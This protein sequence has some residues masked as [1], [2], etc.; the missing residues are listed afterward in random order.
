MHACVTVLLKRLR[1]EDILRQ[2]WYLRT[3]DPYSV[4]SYTDVAGKSPFGVNWRE[5][6]P[7]RTQFIP[8]WCRYTHVKVVH[9]SLKF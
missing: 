7:Y 2:D 3:L 8:S 6:R 4:D 5:A 1:Q 9:T